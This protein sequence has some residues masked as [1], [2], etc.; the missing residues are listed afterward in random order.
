MAAVATM[1][2]GLCG[3]MTVSS[4][5]QPRTI[6][7]INR[8]V[9]TDGYL[10][11]MNHEASGRPAMSAGLDG[12][13]VLSAGNC[14]Q[15]LDDAGEAVAVMFPRETAILGGAVPGLDIAGRTFSV[16]DRIGLGGGSSPLSAEA[17]KAAGGCAGDRELFL[18]H[19]I[20]K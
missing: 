10:A 16:G 17:R 18:V 13:L 14:F 5:D 11:L 9:S 12:E 6:N 8:S 20:E 3:C 7:Q 15:V 2:W 4:T 19:T 1:A